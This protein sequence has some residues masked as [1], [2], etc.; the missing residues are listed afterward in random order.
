MTW[1]FSHLA[2]AVQCNKNLYHLIAVWRDGNI[3]AVHIPLQ[4]TLLI[5]PIEQYMKKVKSIRMKINLL[6]RK[7]KLWQSMCDIPGLL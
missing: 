7:E 5:D 1:I 4:Y 2:F 3:A 6:E